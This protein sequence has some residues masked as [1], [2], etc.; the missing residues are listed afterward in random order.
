MLLQFFGHE[1]GLLGG[2]EVERQFRF[3]SPVAIS[4]YEDVFPHG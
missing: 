4:K 1:T 3:N 2:I